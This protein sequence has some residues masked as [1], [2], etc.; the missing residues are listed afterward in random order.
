MFIGIDFDGTIVTHEFPA[1]GEPVPWAI[2]VMKELQ[3][4][5]HELILY[6]MRSGKSLA[7]AIEY[8][9]SQGIRLFGVNRNPTQDTWT[10]SPK[11]YCHHYIDDAAIGCPLI[12]PPEDPLD[13]ER[14][15][16]NWKK[17]RKF[18]VGKGVLPGEIKPRG[19][20]G[21]WQH[22]IKENRHMGMVKFPADTV[23]LVR[24]LARENV[25]QKDIAE[26]TGMSRAQV[27]GINKRYRN[28]VED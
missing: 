16:V 12:M 3:E 22:V 27:C 19:K 8:I 10:T 17:V 26:K 2:D 13:V 14:P 9:S 7:E 24:K 25:P 28:E 15:Y 20:R 18:L 5:G 21:G 4:Q 11:V 23:R 1:I 6:T